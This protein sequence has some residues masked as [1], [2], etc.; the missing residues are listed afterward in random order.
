MH[1]SCTYINFVYENIKL[2]QD[3]TNY[4]QAFWVCRIVD[5]SEENTNFMRGHTVLAGSFICFSFDSD[6]QKPDIWNQGLL[7]SGSDTQCLNTSKPEIH[8]DMYTWT[9]VEYLLA[10]I[11]VKFYTTYNVGCLLW[12]MAS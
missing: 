7:F 1:A 8:S 10:N 3:I 6:V 11:A 12:H 2:L 9:D 5:Y 4:N